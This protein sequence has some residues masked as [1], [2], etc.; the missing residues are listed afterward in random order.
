MQGFLTIVHFI[1]NKKEKEY[2][3]RMEAARNRPPKNYPHY[4]PPK[5]KEYKGPC[6]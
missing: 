6:Q 5:P 1:Q 2:Q 3:E 4:P